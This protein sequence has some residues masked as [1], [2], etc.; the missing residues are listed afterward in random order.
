MKKAIAIVVAFL[1]TLGIQAQTTSKPAASGNALLWEVSGKG[2]KAPSYLFGTYHLVG[3][4]FT[5][6]LPALM[7]AFDRS[8][9]VV[10]EVIM[11]GEME[12]A[13]K[14]MPLMLLKGT[15]LDKLFTSAEFALVDSFVSKKTGIPMMALNGLK[16]AAVQLTL[17]SFL[18][19]KNISPTNPALDMYLQSE[20][21][22]RGKEV[23][24]LE[25]LE[26]QAAVLFDG[27]IDR[28]K[29][30]LLKTIR[31]NDRVVSEMK[32]LFEDY[33][34]GDLRALEAAFADSK[35]YTPEEIETLLYN[36][37]RNWA[38]QIPAIITKGPAF[39]AV[40]AG[41]LPGNEGL[42][43]LLRKAGYT[44]RATALK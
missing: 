13:Q 11:D 4:D 40:G 10:G 14:L 34:R 6:S 12:M 44:V 2:L 25:T 26:S 20:A 23:V 43:S 8:K 21:K 38:K 22:K 42:I 33:K 39:I 17:I 9:T 30:S 32:K 5:D 19:P 36:R 41:H 27:P 1:T 35:D 16:P 15:T 3:K 18:A 37:N 31:E 28:Q 24:G 7:Q 29:E